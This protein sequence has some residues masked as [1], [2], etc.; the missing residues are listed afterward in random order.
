MVDFENDVVL[1]TCAAGRQATHLIPHLYGKWKRL[2]LA[3][4]SESSEA[5]LKQQWPNAEVV[6]GDMSNPADA[7]RLMKGVTAVYHVGPPQ[8][9]YET[10]C[11]YYMIDAALQEAKN[12][13][14]KHFIFSSVIC[15]QLRKLMNHDCKRFVEE[16]L[17]ESG[18][19]YTILQPSH[20]LD[21][22]PVE[23]LMKQENPV[24]HMLWD[25]KTPFCF[26]ALR[27]LAAIAALIFDQREQHYFA[28]YP[29][30]STWPAPEGDLIKAIGR[31]MGKEIKVEQVE[32]IK[33]V[34]LMAGQF[35]GRAEIDPRRL[36]I[37]ERLLLYYQR[38]GLMGNPGI[39][40][41]LLGRET[42]S[43][44]SY[45]ESRVQAAFKDVKKI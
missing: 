10:E 43:I 12:G 1:V 33:A 35:G 36:D 7:A 41:W 8:H 30:I 25:P 28:M 6:I 24:Q 14:F 40:E 9:P 34:E 45:A 4:H 16:Y 15:S 17:M 18:L 5:R 37:G 23:D 31:A 27:D 13:N 38:R 19:N 11:G 20:F 32:L 39:T 21:M 42:T 2:R 22:I 3:A 29:I 44:E 26:T